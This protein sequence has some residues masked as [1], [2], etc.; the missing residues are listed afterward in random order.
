[1]SL[2][3]NKPL[4]RIQRLLSND[5]LITM[6]GMDLTF[7]FNS[8]ISIVRLNSVRHTL[9]HLAMVSFARRNNQYI[10]VFPARLP[11]SE[12]LRFDNILEPQHEGVN[13][14]FPD[15][16]LYTP[17]M[18]ATV[19]ANVCSSCGLVNGSL[20]TVTSVILEP[21]GKSLTPSQRSLEITLMCYDY[22]W[23]SPS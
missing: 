17:G 13:I 12:Q 15:I 3:S 5:T 7:D 8:M 21:R 16:F 9:N 14:P 1:M 22:S 23:T 20:G 18:P 4:L 2:F 6:D 11:S 10:Y 19:L